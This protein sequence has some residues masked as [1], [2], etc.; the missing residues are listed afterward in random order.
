MLMVL[1]R[2]VVA[3]RECEDQRIVA[4]QLAQLAR[5]FLVVR[6]LVV[7]ELAARDDVR[8]HYR[9]LSLSARHRRSCADG[10]RRRRDLAAERLQR[11]DIYLRER[12]E[13]LDP[14][15]PGGLRDVWG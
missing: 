1:L 12:R 9:R 13:T 10:F 6:Q 15:P 14:V 4:L 11:F 7:R 8:A 5:R 3:A 2:A